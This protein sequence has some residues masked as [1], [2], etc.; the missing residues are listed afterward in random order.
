LIIA[1]LAIEDLRGIRRYIAKSSPH[2]AREFLSDLTAKIAW[3]AE[4][5]FTGH[6][7]MTSSRACGAFP[8]ATVA[9]IFVLILT[10]WWCY[11]S[12]ILGR[13]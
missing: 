8:T 13:M 7:V 12:C 10:A 4:V 6:P 1:P 11:G 9:S 2:Y 5:G 3:I